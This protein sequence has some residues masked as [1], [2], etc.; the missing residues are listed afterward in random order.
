MTED[1]KWKLIL[2]NSANADGQFYYAVKTTGIFCR[3]SCK[4]KEPARRNVMF[5]DSAEDAIAAG[6]RPCKRCRPDLLEYQPIKEIA[7]QAQHVVEQ[8]HSE[9]RRMALELQNLGVSKSRIVQIFKQ[10]FGM[11]PNG[12]ADKIRIDIAREKLE[13]STEPMIDIAYSLGYE[14]LSA[15]FTFFRKHTGLSPGE[16]R[17]G[18]EKPARVEDLFY[19]VYDTALGEIT[20]TER[21]SA[22]ASIQFGR[23]IPDGVREKRTELTDRAASEIREYF[24]GKRK[25]FDLPLAPE[26][27]QFQRKVWAAVCQ[28]PY[29][30]TRTYKEIAEAASPPDI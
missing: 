6:Y 19:A 15:F 22:I 23:Q 9:K 27:T 3:P 28:I 30:E 10:E 4:A 13:K 25:T 26:G 14:S 5:F 16:Y 7:R 24:S 18:K 2:S 12:Y 1:E 8:Y 21:G 17:N 20:I 29:G 11:S